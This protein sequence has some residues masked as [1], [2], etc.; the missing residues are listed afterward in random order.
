MVDGLATL[1]GINEAERHAL[2]Q[3]GRR[4]VEQK[5]VWKRIGAEMTEVYRW[6]LGQAEKPETVRVA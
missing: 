6:V 2:G 5:F 4:L 1:F 3:R